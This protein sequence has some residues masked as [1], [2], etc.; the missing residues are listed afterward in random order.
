MSN[1]LRHYSTQIFPLSLGFSVFINLVAIC[2]PTLL[3]MHV[4]QVLLCFQLYT[5]YALYSFLTS[6][7]RATLP[8]HNNYFHAW[9]IDEK[10]IF[11]EL[12]LLAKMFF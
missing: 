11:L 9:V 3:F 8:I 4:Q 5:H 10:C 12:W 1:V 7:I 2:S 6:A